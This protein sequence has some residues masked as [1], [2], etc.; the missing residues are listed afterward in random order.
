[1][2][3]GSWDPNAQATELTP[4]V[5]GELLAAAQRLD[6]ADFGLAAADAQRLAGLAR[7]DGADWDAAAS[8]LNDAQL[9]ALIRFFTLAEQR[10]PSWKA[11]PRSPVIPLARALRRRGAWPEDLIAWIKRHT[12]N[13][14]LPYGSLAD[15]L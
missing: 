1:M 11:G 7:S 6:T 10:F 12:D 14:F 5:L 9:T 8:G 15:R 3:V 4:S 13:R 2:A